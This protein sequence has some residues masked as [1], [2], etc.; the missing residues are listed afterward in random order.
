V[1]GPHS[2]WTSERTS[3]GRG[4]PKACL[5]SMVVTPEVVSTAASAYPIRRV[6]ANASEQATTTSRH[7]RPRG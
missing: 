5:R 4:W 2:A 7:T 1:V 6:R 3:A